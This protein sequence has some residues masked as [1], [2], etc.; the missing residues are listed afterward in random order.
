MAVKNKKWVSHCEPFNRRAAFNLRF[1]AKWV[2]RIC[3]K[4][5]LNYLD[6][7]VI[8]ED[9]YCNIVAKK[10]KPTEGEYVLEEVHV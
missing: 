1:A 10:S 4:Y 3:R 9:D 5:G 2:M 8:A 7:V 6:L